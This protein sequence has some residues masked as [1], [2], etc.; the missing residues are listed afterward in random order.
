VRADDFESTKQ[1]STGDRRCEQKGREN[2]AEN[3]VL[4]VIGTRSPRVL[5][6]VDVTGSRRDAGTPVPVSGSA[7]KARALNR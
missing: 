3:A 7:A 4:I 1:P 2:N 6:A 5:A